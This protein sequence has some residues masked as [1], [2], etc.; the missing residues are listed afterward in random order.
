[1][2]I[3]KQIPLHPQCLEAHT[4]NSQNL[5]VYQIYNTYIKGFALKLNYFIA[6]NLFAPNVS[7]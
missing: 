3:L 4:C 2:D 7:Y 5:C 1:M 6:Q